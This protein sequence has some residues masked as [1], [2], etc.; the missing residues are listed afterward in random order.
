MISDRLVIV[1]GVGEHV[2]ISITKLEILVILEAK[3]HL[4]FGL[5]MKGSK[6]AGVLG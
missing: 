5:V 1:D 4:G 2:P 6:A 3:W